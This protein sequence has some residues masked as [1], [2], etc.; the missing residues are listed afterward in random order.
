MLRSTLMTGALVL[1]T[2]F[3]GCASTKA[4]NEAGQRLIVY[5][6]ANE[7]ITQGDKDDVDIRVSRE[8]FDGALTVSISD[9]PEGVSVLNENMT[10]ERHEGKFT[11]SLM[12]AP[13]APVVKDHIV[14]VRVAGDNGLGAQESFRLSVEAS[15]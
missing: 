14:H 15:K 8:D 9:L 1:A 2:A 13:D 3:W 7:S 5:R 4:V 11:L 10:I 12:A 6:P